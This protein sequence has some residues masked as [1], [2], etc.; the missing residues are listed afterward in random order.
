MS[1][2][3]NIPS[4]Y[5]AVLTITAWLKIEL[6]SVSSKYIYIVDTSC[7]I[8]TIVICKNKDNNVGSTI[9]FKKY[10]VRLMMSPTLKHDLKKTDRDQGVT[11]ADSRTTDVI[12]QPQR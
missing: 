12:L 1:A 5:H 8:T 6:I 10:L 7:A 11:I 4:F 2:A 3:T 9:L